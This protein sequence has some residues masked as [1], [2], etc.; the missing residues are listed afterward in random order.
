MNQ[1]DA[2]T[3]WY[4][5]TMDVFLNRWFANYEEARQSLMSEGGYLFPYRR[6]FFVCEAEAVRSMV[7]EPDDPDW[8]RINWDGARPA[9]AEAYERLYRK[10]AEVLLKGK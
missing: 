7:L 10:R 6:Q 2:E 3:L 9:D 5:P 8:E 1:V 4:A